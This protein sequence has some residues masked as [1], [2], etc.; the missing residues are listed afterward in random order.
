MQPSLVNTQPVEIAGAAA[1]QQQTIQLAQA[2]A[3]FGV[4]SGVAT[5]GT[6]NLADHHRPSDFLALPHRG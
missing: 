6:G 2:I 1:A 5:A 4:S 3:A